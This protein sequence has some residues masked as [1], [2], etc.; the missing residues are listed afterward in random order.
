M[1]VVPSC[2]YKWSINAFSNPNPVYRSR[3]H[4][5]I[6]IPVPSQFVRYEHNLIMLVFSYGNKKPSRRNCMLKTRPHTEF[7]CDPTENY[8]NVD[9]SWLRVVLYF[10]IK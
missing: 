4:V 8:V 9:L 3:I 5:T 1:L 10:R 7:Y 6:Q 2:V